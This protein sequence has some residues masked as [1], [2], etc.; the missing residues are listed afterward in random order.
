MMTMIQKSLDDWEYQI[1]EADVAEGYVKVMKFGLE[2]LSKRWD[3]MAKTENFAIL[4]EEST[5]H[6]AEIQQLSFILELKLEDLWNRIN[7]AQDEYWARINENKKHHD[8]IKEV[9][10][11][12]NKTVQREL[13]KLM[14]LQVVAKRLAT[15]FKELVGT[16][17]KKLK[18]LEREKDSLHELQF[19]LRNKLMQDKDND[20]LKRTMM[21]VEFAKAFE[22]VN[23]KL[24][25][26]ESMMRVI[27]G[28]HRY[29]TSREKVFPYPLG[30]AETDLEHK[31]S[32]SELRLFW[33]RVA[34]AEAYRYN[35]R[36]VG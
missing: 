23:G 15:K 35:F 36:K 28:I 17:G 22:T 4:N 7:I 3:K 13:K 26:G 11:A 32:P 33:Q 19:A 18:Y 16:I 6:V 21:T 30:I 34:S 2:V 9:D 20:A 29:E 5:K 8:I 12:T 31:Y 24:R 27:R 10:D 14:K 25:K 1:Y